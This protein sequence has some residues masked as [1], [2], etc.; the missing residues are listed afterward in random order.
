MFCNRCGNSVAEGSAFCSVCG[1]ALTPQNPQNAQSP[2]DAPTDAAPPASEPAPV[3]EPAP[4]QNQAPQTMQVQQ[5]FAASYPPQPPYPPPSYPPRQGYPPQPKKKS[6][7]G[8]IVGLSVGGVLLIAALIALFVWPGLL[9]PSTPEVTGYWFSEDRGEALEFRSNGSMRVY[10]ASETY[11]GS[12][13]YDKATGTGVITVEDE[14]YKFAMTKKGLK[15]N[16]MGVYEQADKDFDV[17]EF[18]GERK[19]AETESPEPSASEAPSVEVSE[20]PTEEATAAVGA[21]DILGMWYESTGYA[22]TLEFYDNGTYMMVVAG[23]EFPGTYTFDAA[24]ASWT[25]VEDLTQESYEAAFVGG[26]LMVDSLGYTRDYVEQ[27]DWT[28]NG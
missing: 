17:E 11:K 6:R 18:L 19:P 23:Y 16:G 9:N 8:L 2:P 1:N 20:A 12:Y 14:A 3:S 4:P 13:E 15:V 21:S 22:G 7:T 28:D 5:P 10:T 24:S 25:L 26:E 27:Y